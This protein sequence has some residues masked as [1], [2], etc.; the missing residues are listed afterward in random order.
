MKF[1]WKNNKMYTYKLSSNVVW[2]SYIKNKKINE[3]NDDSRLPRFWYEVFFCCNCCYCCCVFMFL[4]VTKTFPLGSN[5][6]H[7]MCVFVNMYVSTS[8]F[9]RDLFLM[10]MTLEQ[11]NK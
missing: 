9:A 3:N 7:F 10:L 2:F 4:I 11:K 6:I 5:T 8:A 1:K